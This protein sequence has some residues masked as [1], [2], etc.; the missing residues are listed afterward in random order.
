VPGNDDGIDAEAMR[1]DRITF[2]RPVI[3]LVALPLA[4]VLAI[5]LTST[6]FG[7]LLVFPVQIGFHELG[8]AIPS[9]LSSRAA[10]PLP[11]GITFT[12]EE[13]TFFTGASFVFLLAVLAYAGHREKR[14]YAVAVAGA[15]FAA[16]AFF[17]LVLGAE[18]T[19]EIMLLGGIAGELVLSAFV[20]ASF[21]FRAPD[22]LRWD[23]FRIV[24]LP[25]ATVSFVGTTRLWLEIAGGR[26]GMPMGS[27]FGS[28]GD[29]SGDL[30]RLIAEF[31]WTESGL[32]RFYL[33]IAAA[34][35]L[36][37]FTLYGV[38]GLRAFRRTR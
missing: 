38:F 37:M 6:A 35:G 28:H 12:R 17:T 31:D 20:V 8:H 36:A 30:D 26:A 18:R 9:W 23:F 32:V 4:F 13:P 15:L 29:G 1:I 24:A 10:L 5:L 3:D 27:L 22:R 14:P 34:T 25:L 2:D 11:C 16:W 33:A 21:Y 19:R 7:R